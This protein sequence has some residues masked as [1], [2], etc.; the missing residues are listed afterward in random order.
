MQADAA[1]LRTV[2][3][4][5]IAASVA[6]ETHQLPGHE[7]FPAFEGIRAMAALAI[8]AFHAGTYTGLTG[9]GG[10]VAGSWARHLNV[11]VSVF[12]VL[13]AFLLYRP[14]VKAHLAD[15]AAPKLRPYLARRFV[16]IFP[17]YW[18]A[19]FVTA[20]VLH[21]A[22]LGDWWGK[23]RFYSLTQIYWADTALGGLPQ[24]WSLCT[25]LSFYLFLPFWAYLMARAGGTVARRRRIHLLGCAVLYVGALLFRAQLR[26]G[27]HALGYAW[28]PANTDLFALGMWLAVVS[29]DASV[30]TVEPGGLW[31]TVG[32]WPGISW[33][34][35]AC[36]YWAVVHMGF[37][38]EFLQTPTASQEV[39]RQALFGGVALLLV[40]PG[41]VGRQNEGWIRR[42][43]ESRV[44]WSIGVVSYGVYLW[45]LTV[46]SRLNDWLRPDPVP[47]HVQAPVS[48]WVLTLGTIV[49]SLLVAAVSWFALER[50]TL[51][52]VRRD[53]PAE[54]GGRRRVL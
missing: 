10:G 8:V 38:F 25:E 29:A 45:H 1:T 54:A 53:R 21:Q 19:L 51:R 28:L 52:W 49:F 20:T 26:A 22:V 44:L 37:P 3:D 6:T 33:L 27:H 15:E 4:A 32:D 41:V 50:P 17:A 39:V 9:P 46:M 16:R 24:A 2:Y 14:F 11:G 36:A 7:R 18:L 23:L 43:L 5:A 42:M 12:F 48:W 35:A 31:R 40:A 34:A 47:G 13:S 30:R